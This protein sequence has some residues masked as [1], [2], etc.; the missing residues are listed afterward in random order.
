MTLSVPIPTDLSLRE[1]SIFNAEEKSSSIQQANEDLFHGEQK[2]SEGAI[3]NSKTPPATDTIQSNLKTPR[4]QPST[5][6]YVTTS[7]SFESFAL[8]QGRGMEILF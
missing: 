4:R 7:G 5:R 3:A 2:I 8:L 1:Q 6:F